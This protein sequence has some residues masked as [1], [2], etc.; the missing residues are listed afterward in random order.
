VKLFGTPFV[1]YV[2]TEPLSGADIDA[3]LSRFLSPLHKVHAPSKIHNGSENGHLPDATVD[4]ASEILSS[5]DTEIDDASDRELSFRIFLTDERGLNF[6][7][8][9]SESSI[10]PGTVTRVLVE[11]NEGEHERYD[12]SYLS[13]LPEVHKT[14]FSA[15]KT[16]QESISLFSCLEAFLAEEPLGPDDMW[17]CPSCKEHRQANK[18]LDLWKLPD[19]LVFHLK[20]FTYSRYLKNKIDTFV[21]FPVHDLDLSKYVKNKNDQSYLYELYAVSNHYGGL[22]GGHYTAYAK[23][24]DDNEWYHFDDS[25]VSSVNESEIKNSAAYVLF[26]RRVRSETETQTVEM[27]TDMD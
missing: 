2:N 12:S 22:G 5:P 23:L 16:R 11:W 9:Q 21:N 20:R 13:D 6:K 25:H 1:T 26:Y 18:K 7:P 4:E 14:S 27:S 10:S 24:I 15:K 19:I 8:L 17:F 3:V